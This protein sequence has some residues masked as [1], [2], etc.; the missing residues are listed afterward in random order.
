MKTLTAIAFLFTSSAAYAERVQGK[1]EDHFQYITQDVPKT[2]KICTTVEVPVYGQAPASTGD[3]IVGAI[4]GGAI[5]NQFGNGSGKDAMT[6]LGAIAGSLTLGV[7]AVLLPLLPGILAPFLSETVTISLGL[8]GV[9]V[10]LVMGAG[11]SILFC[12]PLLARFGANSPRSIKKLVA[13]EQ[14]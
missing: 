9:L 13:L 6:I 10:A 3:T 5:G 1:I 2:E 8:R 11:G 7:T 12:L 4:I 14:S